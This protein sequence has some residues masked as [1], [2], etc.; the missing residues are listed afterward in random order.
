MREIN[1]KQRWRGRAETSEKWR[2]YGGKE[3]YG[4]NSSAVCGK[5]LGKPD[6]EG[7]LALLKKGSEGKRGILENFGC[8]GLEY[9]R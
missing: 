7:D 9:N 2:L 4:N 5:G 3:M 1:V 6:G 8:K